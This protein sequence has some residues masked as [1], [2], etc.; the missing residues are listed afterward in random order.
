MHALWKDGRPEEQHAEPHRGD[1]LSQLFPIQLCQDSDDQEC[2]VSSRAH[3]PQAADT[4]AGGLP[5]YSWIPWPHISHP[6]HASPSYACSTLAKTLKRNEAF[7]VS[8]HTCTFQ[9]YR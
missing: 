6:S 9:E 2:S 4:Q 1:P 8:V 7:Q 3:H 5:K